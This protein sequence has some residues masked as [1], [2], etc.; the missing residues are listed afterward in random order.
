MYL[1]LVIN[2][3][4]KSAYDYYKKRDAAKPLFSIISN[5]FTH[6]SLKAH[7]N[8]YPLPIN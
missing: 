4:I 5:T 2:K 7:N 6:F 8:L 3:M 1:W